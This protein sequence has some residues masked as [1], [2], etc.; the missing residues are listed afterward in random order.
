[1]KN[2]K[3]ILISSLVTLLIV[4]LA[5]A[6]YFYK[7]QKPKKTTVAAAQTASTNPNYQIKDTLLNIERNK[8][9]TNSR[10]TIITETVFKV[11]PAVVGITV[12]EI[13]EYRD[14][15]SQDPF[16]RQFFGDRIYKRKIKG[17][18]SGTIIS[19]DGYILTNDHVAGNAV[20][21]IVTMTDGRHF[22]AKKIG[23]DMTS[24]IC[25]LKIDAENLPYVPFG[26]SDKILIGEWVIALGNPFGLFEI[27]NKP[28]VTVGVISSLG[29]NLGVDNNRY[30]YDMLQ[31]D[32]AINSGNSGGPLVNSTGQIIG[33]NTLIYSKTGG[34]IGLGFAIP[35][36][37]IKPIIK[38]L[39]T[40]GKVDRNFWTGL[41]IQ[42]INEGIV[43]YFKLSNVQGVIITK[44][45]P[46]SPAEKA[47]L[48]VADII[49]KVDNIKI[50]DDVTLIN[51]MHT[52]ETNEIVT[53]QIIRKNKPLEKSI[54]LEPKND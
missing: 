4:S 17:L 44:I 24:D 41:S 18:G 37:R 36:N 48:K 29:L 51:L 9:I 39:K 22:N 35:I 49:T 13:Q 30:Y 32:A 38:D 2:L 42:T 11:S 31:T 7:N 45:A 20:K 26:N 1:M 27:N 50:Q 21:T 12:T 16:F 34:N 19:P 6:Y 47:G 15:F 14:P 40:K 23:T 28:T 3:P 8:E 25:L 43:N 10:A 5:F 54:K 46:N 33:M 53:F 52:K